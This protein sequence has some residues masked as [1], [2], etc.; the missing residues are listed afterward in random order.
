MYKCRV[1]DKGGRELSPALSSDAIV[2]AQEGIATVIKYYEGI[3]LRTVKREYQVPEMI[4]LSH[5]VPQRKRKQRAMNLSNFH[6][7]VRDDFTCQYCGRHESKLDRRPGKND[8]P[9]EY[10]TREHIIPRDAGGSNDWSNC[11]TACNTCNGRKANR[12]PKQAGMRL[13]SKP[14]VPDNAEIE[15]KKQKYAK[16]LT[17]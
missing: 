8:K 16:G 13:R 10:L 2:W 5:I 3:S 14:Y 4:V 6:L 9:R 17:P 7:F 11:T 12:T 1:F 15:G